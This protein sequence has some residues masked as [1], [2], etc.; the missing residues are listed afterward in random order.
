MDQIPQSVWEAYARDRSPALKQELVIEYL[1]LVSYV[2]AKFQAAYAGDAG[3]L[4]AA[5]L[6]QVGALGLMEA[7]ERYNPVR[8]V[9]FE[10]FAVTRIR[11]AIQDELRRLD[12]VPRSVRK[13]AR[14]AAQHAGETGMITI[15][16]EEPMHTPYNGTGTGRGSTQGPADKICAVE[17]IPGD[18]DPL[19]EASRSQ[20]KSLLVHLVRFLPDD[21]RLILTL[22]YYEDLTFKEIGT[23][24][25]VSES[26]VSQKHSSVLGRLRTQLGKI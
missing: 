4:E 12:W 19:E 24:L 18:S 7:I 2:V 14:E 20:L 5:D 13:K 16:G 22:Y 9:K 10:T 3:M 15:R 26:R 21:E 6:E 23:I 8:G 17:D 11:G 25:K 1:G